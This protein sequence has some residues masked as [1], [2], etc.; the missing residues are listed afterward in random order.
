MKKI[1][2]IIVILFSLVKT[3]AQIQT[4]KNVI[5]S[6][7]S[8]YLRDSII[9]KTNYYIGKSLSVLL[10][11]LKIKIMSYT[12]PNINRLPD[13]LKLSEITLDFNNGETIYARNSLKLRSPHLHIKFKQ[14]ILIPRL[15]FKQGYFL[16]NDNWDSQKAVFFGRSII[17]SIEVRGLSPNKPP[18]IQ[19]LFDTTQH[20]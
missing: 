13:T 17:A 5:I 18:L 12:G 2:I 14:P 4:K 7:T 1:L 11:D 16:D 6:D 20:H 3:E 15:Y 9:P 19:N 8:K 10:K